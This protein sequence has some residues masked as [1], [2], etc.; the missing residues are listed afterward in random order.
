MPRHYKRANE[1]CN[2]VSYMQ[3]KPAKVH[4]QIIVRCML[5]LSLQSWLKYYFFLNIKIHNESENNR[6]MHMYF[7]QKA[8]IIL[9]IVM[10]P[11]HRN[12]FMCEIAMDHTVNWIM[13]QNVLH[14]YAQMNMTHIVWSSMFAGS[15]VHMKS[16]IPHAFYY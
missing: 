15:T 16:E 13:S 1:H 7:W 4:F 11:K 10:T 14:F 5:S 2:S 12:S 9:I 6:D 3:C 8:P